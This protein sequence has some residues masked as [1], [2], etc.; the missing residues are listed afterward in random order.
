VAAPQ[1]TEDAQL[2]ALFRAYRG[3]KLSFISDEGFSIVAIGLLA[4]M[5]GASK[6]K[7][8]AVQTWLTSLWDDYTARKAVV[9]TNLDFS[10]NGPMPYPISEIK[11]E[12]FS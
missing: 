12:V 11:I 8:I 6:P 7:C 2:A 5:Q 1:P 4:A 3:Y 10:N 9:S